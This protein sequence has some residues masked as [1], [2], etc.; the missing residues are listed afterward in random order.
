MAEV[1]DAPRGS[2]DAVEDE[3]R[4]VRR[5]YRRGRDRRATRSGRHFE[6][7]ATETGVQGIRNRDTTD[8]DWIAR[9]VEGRA[10]SLEDVTSD[11]AV[12]ALMGP[13]ARDVLGAVTDN[14][15]SLRFADFC[16]D[17]ARERLV[18][19]TEQHGGEVDGLGGRHE[20]ANDRSEQRAAVLPDE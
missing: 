6:V 19:V 10:V 13:R 7:F 8:A 3:L 16:W 14:D 2:S 18:A 12:L 15:E 5:R 17:G 9:H 20:E 4:L 1:V 11:W